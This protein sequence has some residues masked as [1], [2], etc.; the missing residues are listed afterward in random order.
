VWPDA[1]SCEFFV[2]GGDTPALL[3]L[4]EEPLDEAACAVQARAKA[5]RPFSVAPGWNG[6]PFKAGEFK[7]H[8]SWSQLGA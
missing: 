5:N 3:D 4:F 7:L 8:D 1:D 2:A 6:G